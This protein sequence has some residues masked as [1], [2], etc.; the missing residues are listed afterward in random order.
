MQS[1]K[2][3]EKEVLGNKDELNTQSS[4]WSTSVFPN[5]LEKGPSDW[6]EGW[7]DQGGLLTPRK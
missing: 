4:P 7:V 3:S 1:A 2:L 5:R 6:C